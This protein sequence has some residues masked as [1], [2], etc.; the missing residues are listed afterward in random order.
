MKI[1]DFI[2]IIEKI[3]YKGFPEQF[4]YTIEIKKGI[5]KIKDNNVKSN[6]IKT[7]SEQKNYL[8]KLLNDINKNQEEAYQKT[9]FLKFFYGK[10][11]TLFY[12]YLKSNKEIPNLKNEVS[13]LIYYIIGNKYR[14]EPSNFIFKSKINSGPMPLPDNDNMLKKIQPN[15]SNIK[16]IGLDLG[17]LNLEFIKNNVGP[18]EKRKLLRNQLS[19]DTISRNRTFQ[20]LPFMEEGD[21][22]ELEK[23]M[24]DMYINIE[25][26]LKEIMK[27]NNITEEEI[28]KSSL[29]KNQNYLNKKG[30][31]IQNC[32]NNIYEQILLFYINLVGN[33]PPR[34][35]IL[36][37]KEESTLE[38]LISFIYLAVFCPYHSLFIIAKPD[39]LNIDIIYEM[40]NILE[41][42]YANNKNIQSYILF[43]FDD[44]GKSEIGNELLKIC[45][46]ADEPLKN[47]KKSQ[48]SDLI[49]DFNIKNNYNYIQIISSSK[50]GLG[51]THYII[52]QCQNNNEI[53]IPFPI[54]GE[55]KRQ[56]IM[57]RLK[58]LNLK[59]DKNSKYGL[60][61][62]FSDTKQIELFED[63][64]FSFLIQKFYSNNENIFCYENNINIY[65]EIPNGFF[66]FMDKFTIL[67]KFRIN[68]ITKLPKLELSETRFND[69]EDMKDDIKLKL[70]SLFDIQKKNQKLNH[71]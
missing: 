19:K 8:T 69:F 12:N 13:N 4:N 32:G 64:L 51:K 20:T 15:K 56:T 11:L 16:K 28:F 53:Y 27:I 44:I 3:A 47:K 1:K 46:P 2:S 31:F 18:L 63:F 38:E 6:K 41:K 48:K 14:K 49:P 57:R 70:T 45:K 7:I 25:N 10:Q 35:S 67:N 21:E 50:A 54:G 30:F 71:H 66:F 60:H 24:E 40:E 58:E 9:K 26:Y 17:G 59:I 62:D 39:K 34:F 36:L 52:K 42:I 33:T 55:V 23:I 22:K 29:I 61:L 37:C 68:N 43:L 5:K 65:I